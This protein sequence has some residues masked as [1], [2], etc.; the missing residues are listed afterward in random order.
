MLI[1]LQ[2]RHHHIEMKLIRHGGDHDVVPRHL[3]NHFFVEIRLRRISGI[4]I[5]IKGLPW[6]RRGENRRIL[7]LLHGAGMLRAYGNRT[8][9]TLPLHVIERRQNLI[10]RDHPSAHYQDLWRQASAS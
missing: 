6:E 8:D 1:V 4:W 3:R 2:R 5:G 10:D 9:H 7:Q